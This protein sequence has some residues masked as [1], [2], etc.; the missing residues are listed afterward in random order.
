MSGTVKR[1]TLS[2]LNAAEDIPR[3]IR[4]Y[5]K[6]C[7]GE[8]AL[9]LRPHDHQGILV[10]HEKGGGVFGWHGQANDAPQKPAESLTLKASVALIKDYQKKVPGEGPITLRGNWSG[11]LICEDGMPRVELRRKLATYGTLVITSIPEKGWKYQVVRDEKWF[12]KP[13]DKDGLAP[14]LTTAIEKGLASAMGLLG[15]ACSMRDSHRRAAFDA[16]YA[17]AHPIKPAREGKDPIEKFETKANQAEK[18]PTRRK[19]AE[20]SVDSSASPVQSN[21]TT[22]TAQTEKASSKKK[23]KPTKQETAK[24]AASATQSSTPQSKTI[25]RKTA[26]PEPATS[27]TAAPVS[28]AGDE[29]DPAKDKLLMDAF[30]AAIASAIGQM[31]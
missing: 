23:A 10:H 29:I 6:C 31:N 5:G 30:G 19:K 17:E 28:T 4:A 21:D 2:F 1:F 12:S 24:T 22:A 9:V 8:C 3:L 25:R 15:E 20:T 13:G 18:A 7:N 11:H 16:P 14:H 27:S 26:T